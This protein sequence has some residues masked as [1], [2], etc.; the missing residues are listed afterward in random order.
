MI[1]LPQ[2]RRQSQARLQEPLGRGPEAL[3]AER[4]SAE[5]G[6]SPADE[7]ATLEVVWESLCHDAVSPTTPLQLPS[8]STTQARAGGQRP[9]R[10]HNCLADPQGRLAS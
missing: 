9:V 1:D 7:L 5:L 3:S 6:W 2:P 4:S 10:P 8:F